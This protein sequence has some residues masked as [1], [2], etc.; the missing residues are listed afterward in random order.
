M[1]LICEKYDDLSGGGIYIL[2][3]IEDEDFAVR[4]CNQK[5]KEYAINLKKELQERFPKSNYDH[6]TKEYIEQDDYQ[7]YK[8]IEVNLLK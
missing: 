4:Y 7:G 2:G 8:Y 1:Y 5:N 6:I 3:Y